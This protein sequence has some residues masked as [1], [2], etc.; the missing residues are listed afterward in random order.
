MPRFPP[1]RKAGVL[2]GAD[3]GARG[4]VAGLTASD[5]FT[6]IEAWLVAAL[7][8]G[9]TQAEAGAAAGVSERTVRRRLE[10]EGFAD[11]VLMERSL[12]VTQ[13]SARL[14]GLTGGAVDALT[15]LLAD[16]VPASVR[17]RAALG[18]LEAA[19]VWRDCG[20][21]EQRIVAIE[22]ELA[23]ERDAR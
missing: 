13:T 23:S 4:G 17:L 10:D 7:A 8:A 14:T 19:R 12:L 11:R 6:A 9:A 22:A 18:V 3:P 21:V 20:E 15:G 1:A 5:R 2:M 16:T